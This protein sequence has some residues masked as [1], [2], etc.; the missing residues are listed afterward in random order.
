MRIAVLSDIHGNSIALGAVLADIDDQ[1]GV[2][3][4]WVLGDIVALGHDPVTVLERL[5]QLP[6]VR[7]IRGN[8][9]RYVCTGQRPPPTF[10]EAKANPDLLPILVECAGT[11]AWTQGVV[12]NAGWL[13]WLADLP[14][15]QNIVLPDGTRFLGVHASPGQD[16][17]CGI[18]SSLSK[19]EV[20][21]LV[22][23]CEAELICV[24]HTHLP[25]D[26]KV[27]EKRIINLG[28]AS[29]PCP[30]DLRASYVILDADETGYR[31][32][33][34]RAEYDH[35]AVIDAV[36]R[37]QHPGAGYIIKHMR[38]QMKPHLRK[39]VTEADLLNEETRHSRAKYHRG[40]S[41]S[42]KV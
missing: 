42:D 31:I 13:D 17:G 4:Y 27:D 39:P 30:P 41:Q 16:T 15:E 32:I 25:L 6:N 7:F 36:Q 33:H 22:A 5:S 40:N 12:T 18:H 26:I 20:Q 2:D 19:S 23:D 37:L 24:G 1:G 9:D 21:S 3:S 8:T 10:E 11:F 35:N 34:R 14:L 29:N 38:G 28:S